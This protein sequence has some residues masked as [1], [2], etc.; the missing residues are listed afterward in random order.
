MNRFYTVISIACVIACTAFHYTA[1]RNA[2]IPKKFKIPSELQ[3][4][5]LSN[6]GII[7]GCKKK[8]EEERDGSDVIQ[9]CNKQIKLAKKRNVEILFKILKLN[10]IKKE[11]DQR[12]ALRFKEG[13][14]SLHL[15]KSI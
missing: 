14:W 8:K 3:Q 11:E 9:K 5:L 7:I 2:F 15:D 13:M 1:I 4:Q 12:Y 6:E 10:G